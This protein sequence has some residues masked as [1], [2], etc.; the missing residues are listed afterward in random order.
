MRLVCCVCDMRG[1]GENVIGEYKLRKFNID[2][3]GVVI[4]EIIF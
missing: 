3:I 1:L 4:G 2:F